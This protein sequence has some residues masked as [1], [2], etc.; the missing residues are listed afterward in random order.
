MPNSQPRARPPAPGAGPAP[1]LAPAP[2]PA[3]E[4][5]R[6]RKQTR[7]QELLDAA[8]ALF[9]EKGFAATRAEEVARRAGVSKGTL[10]LYYPSKEELFKAVVRRSLSQL[11]ADGLELVDAYEG[12]TA[13]LLRELVRVWWERFGS[14]PAAGIHKVIVAEVRNFPEL[15][16]FYAQEVILPADRLFAGTVARGIARGEFRALP[17]HDVAH[18]LMAPLIFMALH[19][20]SFGA[21]PVHGP[22][23]DPATV[24]ATQLDLILHGL[25]RHPEAA[26]APRAAA[27]RVR[28][29]RVKRRT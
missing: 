26:P 15:A 6:R 1:D 10:Y 22:D 4:P 19:R 23:L 14:T 13:E 27:V 25:Q 17:V 9:V 28:Q 16:Q 11:I 3:A 29:P 18:A 20:H 5:R 2:V 8:L 7:P 21:C 24:L 12:P